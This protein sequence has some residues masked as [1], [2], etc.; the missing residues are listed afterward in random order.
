[1]NNHLPAGH[2]RDRSDEI[3]IEAHLLA[4]IAAGDADAFHALWGRYRGPVHAMCL[5]VIGERAQAEDAVQEAFVRIWRGAGGYD[6]VRGVPAAWIMTVARNVARTASRTR[7]PLPVVH[8]PMAADGV[9]PIVDRLWLRHALS[10]LS[11]PEQLAL[12]LAYFADLSHAQV[13][14]RL[15]EPLG[16]VKA[17]IRRALLRLAEQVGER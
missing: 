11:E 6:P 14:A 12:E 13:A 10:K 15:G 9:E 5:A 16:T 17:R 1:M 2:A 7:S 4:Q 3:A 8:E